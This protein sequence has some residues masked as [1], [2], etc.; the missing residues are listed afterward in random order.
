[1]AVLHTQQTHSALIKFLGKSMG[2]NYRFQNAIPVCLNAGRIKRSFY[3]SI[4]PPVNSF[5][6]GKDDEECLVNFGAEH[7]PHAPG[8][9]S[10]IP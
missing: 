1:M 4:H 9:I 8:R 7:A 2:K 10:A 3:T 6:T 5:P